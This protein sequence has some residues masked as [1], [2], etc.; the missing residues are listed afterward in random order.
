[1]AH[2]WYI[3]V[4][5]EAPPIARG[6]RKITARRVRLKMEES[7]PDSGLELVQIEQFAQGEWKGRIGFDPRDLAE[8]VEALTQLQTAPQAS[9]SSGTPDPAPGGAQ[10]NEIRP[11]DLPF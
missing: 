4:L 8:V 6:R 1:M 5:A 3:E 2:T 11:E 9:I 7:L 10:K